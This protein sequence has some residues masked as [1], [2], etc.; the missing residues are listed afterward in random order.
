MSPASWSCSSFRSQEYCR[1]LPSMARE[2]R[3]FWT[4]PKES[5]GDEGGNMVLRGVPDSG[6]AAVGEPVG[7]NVGESVG[8]G[9]GEPD[10]ELVGYA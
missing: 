5:M 8:F 10:G 1:V 2:Y 7:S 3:I 4:Q 6:R 9:V